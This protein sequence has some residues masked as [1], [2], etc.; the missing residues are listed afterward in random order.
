MSTPE[1]EW[2]PRSS[3]DQGRDQCVC[4]CYHCRPVGTAGQKCGG[5]GFMPAEEPA[6]LLTDA[7]VL[8]ATA[9]MAGADDKDIAA[10]QEDAHWFAETLAIPDPTIA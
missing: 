6:Q 2:V 8:L 1:P 3:S 5:C 4:H 9:L 10:V 7:A